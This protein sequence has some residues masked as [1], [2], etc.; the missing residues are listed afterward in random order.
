MDINTLEQIQESATK[1]VYNIK[2]FSYF[3]YPGTSFPGCETLTKKI[4]TVVIINLYYFY[5][6]VD[7]HAKIVKWVVRI[8]IVPFT[9]MH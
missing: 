6:V 9:Y 2:H 3:L 1:L 5:F 8:V 7:S 4:V